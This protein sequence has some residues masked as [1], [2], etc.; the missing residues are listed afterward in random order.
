MKKLTLLALAVLTLAFLMQAP[1]AGATPMTLSLSDGTN[2]QTIT[3]GSLADINPITGAIT[4]GGSVG[5]WVLNVATGTSKPFL[6][7]AADP[8]L[9]LNSVD[10]YASNNGTLTLTLIDSGFSMDNI[11]L[12]D[13]VGGTLGA[14]TTGT[15]SASLNGHQVDIGALFPS[16]PHSISSSSLAAYA[17]AGDNNTLEIQ[18]VL[19]VSGFSP[20]NHNPITETSF[21]H[22]LSSVP[23]PST[24][25]LMGLGLLGAA[26]FMKRAIA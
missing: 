3:D 26:F 17:L 8:Q 24:F 9:D 7:S 10:A 25:L 1:I 13:N 11:G 2:T 20:N 18:D 15:F 6:G 4:W 5:S 22:N 23:E 12:I 16:T 19:T 21:D 14:D